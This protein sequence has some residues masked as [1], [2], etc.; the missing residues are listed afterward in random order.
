VGVEWAEDGSLGGRGGLGVVDGVDE[1]GQPKDIG[2]K[3][4]FLSRLDQITVDM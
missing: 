4:E 1:Q 3:D 2:E